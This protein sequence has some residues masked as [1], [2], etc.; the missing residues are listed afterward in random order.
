MNKTRLFIFFAVV[1]AVFIS[2]GL[3]AGT[4]VADVVKMD[5]KAYTKHEKGIVTFTHKK[6]NEEYKI[7]CGECHHD[8]KG[9]PLNLKMGDNVQNCIECHKKP[10]DKP[11]GKDAPKLTQ[12]EAL[13]YHAEAM[14]QQCQGCHRDFNKKNNTKSAPTTCVG[15]HPKTN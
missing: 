15:C 5:N 7:T 8:N 10:G 3:N 6:H 14:H 9:K 2:A 12:K 4:K 11:K 1:V 13:E